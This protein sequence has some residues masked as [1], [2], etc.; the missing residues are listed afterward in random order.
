M[1]MQRLDYSIPMERIA[2]FADNIDPKQE[3][4]M[5]FDTFVRTYVHKPDQ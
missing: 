4:P 5:T 1:F 3:G 2:Q